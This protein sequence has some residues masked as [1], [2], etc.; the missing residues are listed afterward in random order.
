MDRIELKEAIK[1]ILDRLD[2]GIDRA[3]RQKDVASD[4]HLEQVLESHQDELE[5]VRDVMYQIVEWM[6]E[7][8][9]EC[10]C[11]HKTEC[12]GKI[13]EGNNE[14]VWTVVEEGKR[15]TRRTRNLFKKRNQTNIN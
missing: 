2:S 13:V 12:E 4:G 3:D 8:D 15:F 5:A 1:S 6:R 9:S 7:H 10:K 11:Y 14:R